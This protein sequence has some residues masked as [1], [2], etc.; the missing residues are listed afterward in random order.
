MRP[1]P[2]SGSSTSWTPRAEATVVLVARI[3]DRLG[4]PIDRQIAENLYA[5]LATDTDH[6]R[7]ADAAAHCWRRG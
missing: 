6:F 4:I 2:V 3:L 5:G 7:H 1:T